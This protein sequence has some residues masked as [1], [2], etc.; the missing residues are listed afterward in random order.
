MVK[1]QNKLA[2]RTILYCFLPIQNEDWDEVK[3]KTDPKKKTKKSETEDTKSE[4]MVKIQNENEEEYFDF[5]ESA[6]FQ[7]MN[8]SRP[9]LKSIDALQWG[10][11]TPIQAATIPTG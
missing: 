6:T 1:N 3:S 7:S 2:N 5:D 8:L 9:L 11:P 10:H 4:G